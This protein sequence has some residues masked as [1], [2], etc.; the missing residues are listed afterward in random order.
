MSLATHVAFATSRG[1]PISPRGGAPKFL[2][3]VLGGTYLQC[4]PHSFH[5]RLFTFKEAN[6]TSPKSPLYPSPLSNLENLTRLA[7]ALRDT[8]EILG[9]NHSVGFRNS[10][11]RHFRLRPPNGPAHHIVMS[12]AKF[13]SSL[14]DLVSDS[15]DDL[16]GLGVI[17]SVQRPGSS[18]MPPKNGRG[19]P[20]T[21]KVTKPAPKTSATTRRA[22]QRV[23]VAVEKETARKALIEK[24]NNPKPVEASKG[25]RA[26]G[27]KDVEMEDA[28]T[29]ASP[30]ASDKAAKPKARGRP[31]KVSQEINDK[32]VP[33]S[34]S[35]TAPATRRPGRTASRVVSAPLE[36]IEEPAETV[37]EVTEI[38]ETRPNNDIDSMEIDH[39]EQIE[40]EDMSAPEPEPRR[41][42]LG[43]Q[44]PR[45]L[46]GQ[47]ASE[48]GEPALRRRL[49]EMSR[50][51]ESLE[52]KY[53][54]L[55]EVAVKDAERNFD[56]LKKQGEE[57]ANGK[58]NAYYCSQKDPWD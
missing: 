40:L 20:G 34:T 14:L 41:R 57:K 35:K 47:D 5:S 3:K 42:S 44:S 39:T 50:K 26:R 58:Y 33:E 28:P 43:S 21:S 56:K 22:N 36:Q 46:A 16:S 1:P 7:I 24:S 12:T 53:R 48:G 15:E 4:G 52:Q 38:P 19:R 32:E 37:E 11:K 55:R 51:F 2:V 23:A 27:A 8:R 17:T 6:A 25:R 13:Q 9:Q 31:R 54:D 30:P 29:L 45:K 18:A 49:G 10:P